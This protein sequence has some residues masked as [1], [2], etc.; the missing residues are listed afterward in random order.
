MGISAVVLTK[1][2]E[3]RIRRCLDS[4]KGWVDEIII[5]DDESNDLEDEVINKKEEEKDEIFLLN[6]DSFAN[7]IS[8][9]SPINQT[10]IQKEMIPIEN[11][12]SNRESQ[13]NF[14]Q[15]DKNQNSNKRKRKERQKNTKSSNKKNKKTSLNEITSFNEKKKFEL[16]EKIPEEINYEIIEL[17]PLSHPE[18]QVIY[19]ISDLHIENNS[20]TY[21]EYNYVF[22][23]LFELL[24]NEKEKKKIL[25]ITGDILH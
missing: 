16:E 15:N 4:L 17:N 8:G 9:I 25:V 22:D 7:D 11:L 20:N 14:S 13:N 10:Q 23:K 5:V 21:E 24:K 18:I 6:P 1:N 19:H 2:E 3:R 12:L